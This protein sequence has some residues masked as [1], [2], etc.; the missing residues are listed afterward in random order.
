M[1]QAMYQTGH[2]FCCVCV[3]FFTENVYVL[4]HFLSEKI[5]ATVIVWYAADFI[6]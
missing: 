6:H 1:L 3:F 4:N 5:K 2:V